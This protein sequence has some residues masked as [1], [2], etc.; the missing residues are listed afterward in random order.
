MRG[1]GRGRGR[2]FLRATV[3]CYKCHK[4]GHYQYECP[5]WEKEVN[6]AEVEEDET[7][8]L[9]SYVQMKDTG[10]GDVW[11]LDSGCSNHMSGYTALF[12]NLDE[13]FRH[14]VRLGNDSKMMV[15]GKGNTTLKLNG[16][17]HVV[18]EVYFVPELKNNLLSLGQLQEKGLSILIENN[19]C[20]IYHPE[21]GLIIQAEMSSNRMF[22]LP[23]KF[24][25]TI[26]VCFNTTTHDISNLWHCRYGHLSYKGLKTL[27]QKKMVYGLPQFEVP[28]SVCTVCMIG[29]QHRDPIS[30]KSSWRATKRLQL[31]H[32]DI[33]GP[34]TPISNSK[35][36]I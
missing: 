17:N 6:Y 24:Q 1:G 29:K 2:Q 34:I 28:T 5:S 25:P 10:N 36:G 35:R 16:F 7:L 11:Y 23:T 14:T 3:E 4:L 20:K 26:P 15:M 19:K 8:L 13:S 9:M 30:K 33:C 18:T 27:Q 31:I 12:C 32:A 21:K 22:I